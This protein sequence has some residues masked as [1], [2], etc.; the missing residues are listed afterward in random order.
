MRVLSILY[1]ILNIL[2]I[3]WSVLKYKN[4]LNPLTIFLIPW[5]LMVFGY[6]LKFIKYNQLTYYTYMVLYI[7]TI[8]YCFGAYLGSIIKN[9]KKIQTNKRN[10]LIDEKKFKK[11]LRTI[12]LVTA[13]LSGITIMYSIFIIF[14]RYG[15]SFIYKISQIYGERSTGSFSVDYIPYIGSFIYISIFV[16]IF[17]FIDYGFHPVLIIPILLTCLKPFTGGAR[18]GLVGILVMIVIAFLLNKKEKV[19][20]KDKKEK[21]VKRKFL[22][23]ITIVSMFGLL[24]FISNQRSQY[25]VSSSFNTYASPKFKKI[26]NK[27]PAAY[28]MYTYFTSPLGVLNEYLKE[29]PFSFGKNTLFPIYNVLN[30]I[31]FGI[32]V[33]RY[34]TFYFIPMRSNVGTAIRELI[35]D[36]TLIIAIIFIFLDGII[37]GNSYKRMKDNNSY[38]NRY[39][40][41]FLFFLVSMSWFM[42]FLRDANIIL[43]MIG[44]YIIFNELDKYKIVENT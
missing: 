31:G 8:V 40:V 33:E 28:Q 20:V 42:W 4:K 38:K 37:V 14:S 17:Y 32:P 15:T 11:K 27:V 44:G 24:I 2:V 13:S 26:I 25:A 9:K 41:S 35:E 19:K 21:N 39:M 34:Q 18:Q 7:S 3:M 5:T 16:G 12:L 23:I 29:E 6:E 1:I 30:K 36:Y 10:L 22:L 43:A